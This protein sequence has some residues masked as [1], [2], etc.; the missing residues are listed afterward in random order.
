M[1]K[2][3]RQR[4]KKQRKP[5]AGSRKANSGSRSS[6]AAST[7]TVGLEEKAR[8]AE[9]AGDLVRARAGFLRLYRA[10]AEKY[11]ADYLRISEGAFQQL[12][13]EKSLFKAEETLKQST[14]LLSE[15]ES[16][17]WGMR[18]AI[19]KEEWAP[20]LRSAL[21]LLNSDARYQQTAVDVIMASAVVPD[22]LE[23]PDDAMHARTAMELFCE[24][25]TS[26]ALH[27]ARSV[28]RSSLFAP[29]S[30]FLKGV[31][32]LYEG[33]AERAAEAFRRL[34]EGSAAETIA[35][36]LLDC[37]G[38]PQEQGADVPPTN[39]F[40]SS[41]P[42]IVEL[43]GEP[44]LARVLPDGLRV[45]QIKGLGA[46]YDAVRDKFPQSLSLDAGWA[47]V[48]TSLFLGAALHFPNQDKL[49]SRILSRKNGPPIDGFLAS[50]LAIRGQER[51]LFYADDS[52]PRL[53]K[54]AKKMLG[55]WKYWNL[56]NAFI[57]IEEAK[58]L[59]E[60]QRQ[61]DY[62]DEEDRD[63]VF[64]LL[65]RA[66]EI[67]PES[68][69]VALKRLEVLDS[70]KATSERN[71]FLDEA[72]DRFPENATI[73]AMAGER[74]VE[75]SAW[76][77]A[78]KYFEKAIERDPTNQS[79]VT[80]M[81]QCALN[82]AKKY[83][84]GGKNT[85]GAEMMNVALRYAPDRGTPFDQI[86][87]VMARR[88]LFAN[89]FEDDPKGS[90]DWKRRAM[91]HAPGDAIEFFTAA[92]ACFY[93]DHLS[94]P[95]KSELVERM[96]SAASEA[97]SASVLLM[98]ETMTLIKAT[99]LPSNR[100]Q[101]IINELRKAFSNRFSKYVRYDSEA[102]RKMPAYFEHLRI[103]DPKMVS[104]LLPAWLRSRSDEEGALAADLIDVAIE[105]GSRYRSRG[106]MTS[107]A[108]MTKLEDRAA[109]CAAPELLQM[110]RELA[111]SVKEREAR[112]AELRDE[113]FHSSSIDDEAEE[114]EIPI[115]S[116]RPGPSPFGGVPMPPPELIEGMAE[117]IKVSS[118]SERESM[119]R[120][121][122]MPKAEWNELIRF[123]KQL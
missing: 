113:F 89:L 4:T 6:G 21:G 8:A 70:Y 53:Y 87:F 115:S 31:A 1:P 111:N 7:S 103:H 22:D 77:K 112:E 106:R 35:L 17:V 114:E 80:S 13:K 62:L 63:E 20:A 34:P 64:G 96:G 101:K 58:E 119:R 108:T 122:G 118:P 18:L 55:D 9:A 68:E 5:N 30:L 121:V 69:S 72:A 120:E 90:E 110:A 78:L 79:T 38:R 19:A 2:K 93:C 61:W 86:G 25:K 123:L 48:L 49:I 10:D 98:A 3:K 60:E 54:A 41:V 71:R 65:A 36:T 46:T 27:E 50:L 107:S 56:V 45:E 95:S 32:A 117:A 104:K 47:A 109:A 73:L 24:G 116:F 74:C 14:E 105:S 37:K 57:L 33:R 16:A 81:V 42:L 85:K 91:N 66:V 97:S 82:L 28:P 40:A 26:E 92:M 51:G 15:N 83:Y 102:A 52:W 23:L 43:C 94:M 100:K 75:R 12:L 99:P 39:G 29:W 59:Q 84:M 67:A 88:S 76:N 11:A 44:E